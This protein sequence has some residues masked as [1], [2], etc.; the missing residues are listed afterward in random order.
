MSSN[1]ARVHLDSVAR[2]AV[3]LA[4][5]CV[6]VMAAVAAAA[7]IVA[8]LAGGRHG[9]VA[10][11]PV[12]TVLSGSMAPAI[13]TGDLIVDR[14]L[15]AGTARHLHA[16]QIVSF[17]AGTGSQ[18]VITHRITGVTQVDGRVAYQTKG[19][20]NNGPDGGLRP[21]ATAVG[22]VWLVIP[23]GGYLLAALHRPLVLGLLLAAPLLWFTAAA[24]WRRARNSDQTPARPASSQD[25]PASTP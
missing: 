2:L 20:A 12:M 23:R 19:D 17:R 24:L 4:K 25:S 21:A 22:V 13:R 14:P 7:A 15:S 16:G 18:I 8:A 9:A 5:I 1:A 6:A 10:G 11:Y 3:A